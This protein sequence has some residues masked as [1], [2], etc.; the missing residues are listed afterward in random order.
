M[1]KISVPAIVALR[2]LAAEQS[3]GVVDNWPNCVLEAANSLCQDKENS[4]LPKKVAEKMTHAE[5]V[6]IS[7]RWLSHEL[8]CSFVLREMRH[9]HD[10]GEI[11]DAPGIKISWGE[12]GSILVECKAT[13]ADYLADRQKKFRQDSR[14]GVGAFRFFCAPGGIILPED[15]PPR[16]GLVVVNGRRT[17]RMAVGLDQEW[18]GIRLS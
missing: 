6:E 16:W 18:R 10:M 3:T 12:I 4:V 2:N 9:L 14:G 15:L 13:R 11:Q 7:H 1:E 5:L 17:L 8:Q